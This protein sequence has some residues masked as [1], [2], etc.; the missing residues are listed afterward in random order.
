MM[1]PWDMVFLA[2]F[3][4]YIGIRA[5]FDRQARRE[6][7]ALKLSDARERVLIFIV[8]VGSVLLPVI[9]LFTPLLAFA[10]YRL[11]WFVPWFGAVVMIGGLWLFWR[12]HA[13]LGVNWSITLE[14][15]KDHQLVKH[16]VYRSIRHP[17]YA[18]IWLFSLAQGL[19]LQNWLAGWSALV[20]FAAL[21]A[22]RV[23]REEQMMCEKFG[24]QYVD[25][26]RH[27]GRLIPRL[28]RP[29]TSPAEPS[30]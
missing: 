17:M 7:K 30:A 19:L 21:Y 26:M 2:G 25:Y 10:D 15:R 28:R 3:A 14:L 11:P 16:G 12:S 27:T 4:V 8:V 29:H 6:E 13:D 18:A 23:R 5:W 1:R 9:Y 20:T 24:Q 22:F